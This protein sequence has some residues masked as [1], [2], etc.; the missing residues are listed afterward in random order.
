MAEA[1]GDKGSSK[2][3]LSFATKKA[4]RV[5]QKMLQK[6]GQAEK[7]TDDNYTEF[8]VNFN[9]QQLAA[10]RLQKEL[11]KYTNNA[12]VLSH[13]TKSFMDLWLELYEPE[14]KGYSEMQ[15]IIEQKMLLWEDLLKK[16]QNE[17]MEPLQL[18]MSKFPETKKLVERRER[19][20]VDYDYAK[21]EL[22]AARQ[23]KKVTEVKLQQFEDT[24]H[25]AK[26]AF[27]EVTDKLYDELP[28]L[29]DSRIEFYA[30]F[31]RNMS[32]IELKFHE[33]MA[34]LDESYNETMN[35]LHEEAESGVHT[36]R[37]E[38]VLNS[39]STLSNLNPV[40]NSPVDDEASLPSDDAEE[41][42]DNL[43]EAAASSQGGGDEPGLSR[44]SS[45]KDTPTRKHSS[46]KPPPSKP[47]RSDSTL[48]D[49]N[50]E[51]RES[52]SSSKE[53]ELPLKPEDKDPPPKPEDKDPPPKPEKPPLE[54]P[55]DDTKDVSV[56][57]DAPPTNEERGETEEGDKEI[58]PE[59]SKEPQDQVEE[60]GED[61]RDERE[62]Q[63]QETNETQKEE[64][65]KKEDPV[66]EEGKEDDTPPAPDAPQNDQSPNVLFKVTSRHPY[67]GEDEDEL[68]FDK[69]V[70]IHVIPY[71]NPD[72]EEDGWLMGF[73]PGTTARGIFPENFT[74]RL[75]D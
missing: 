25:N 56:I 10:S 68:T 35:Q 8:V 38:R 7:T 30:T 49:E 72:D 20:I 33:E 6:V 24:Y 12:K 55:T 36:S 71:D 27:D 51:R 42:G 63:Q 39:E 67:T 54:E 75:N 3:I 44:T 31:F 15:S 16:I 52:A 22:E 73:I 34:K 47:A 61:N 17:M 48:S 69:G 2:K 11:A 74:E 57:E 50:K 66:P 46:N 40:K 45:G 28:T 29:F 43:S 1:R 41:E 70:V 58:E 59:V 14:W 65:D 37:K 4:R 19:K 5:Q 13:S 21:R 9:K 23:N 32:T 26:A 60:E 64:E 18:Y 53:K 62:Q